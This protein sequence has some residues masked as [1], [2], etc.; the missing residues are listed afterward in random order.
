VS[1]PAPIYW[2]FALHAY[3]PCANILALRVQSVNMY[4]YLVDV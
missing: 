2:R 1:S 3:I 4:V